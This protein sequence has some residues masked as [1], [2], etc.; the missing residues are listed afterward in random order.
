METCFFPLVL[1]IFVL[2]IRIN[3]ICSHSVFVIDILLGIRGC[4]VWCI[5]LFTNFDLPSCFLRD[6]PDGVKQM[7]NTRLK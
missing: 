7:Y 6:E 5:A 2:A 1:L 3:K 4:N